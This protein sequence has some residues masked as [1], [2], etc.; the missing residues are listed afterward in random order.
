M[1]QTFHFV[2]PVECTPGTASSWQ[3]VDLDSYVSGLGSDVTGVILHVV[4]THASTSYAIG[5]RKNGSTDNRRNTMYCAGHGWVAIGVDSS[6]IFEL[7]VGETSSID[8]YIVGY[9]TTGVTLHT[10]AVDRT[11]TSTLSVWEDIDCSA[12][13]PNAIAL[14][15][16]MATSSPADYAI[17]KNGSSDD[18]SSTLCNHGAALIGCDTSQIFEG[19]RA[20]SYCRFWLVGY[21]TDGLS[22]NTNGVDRSLSATGSYT[23]KTLT[24]GAIGGVIEV[25]STASSQTYA[26]RKNGSSED[27]YQ[28][29]AYRHQFGIVE[30]DASGIIEGKISNTAVDFFEIGIATAP[31]A[32]GPSGISEVDTV[33]VANIAEAVT[34]AWSSIDEVNTVT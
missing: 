9:T 12:E 20:G 24:S 27:I 26:L 32:S 18:R 11:P 4:N 22:M 7:Y 31:A 6:H 19:K 13:A 25:K 33:A 15:F 21:A 30:A 5:F 23:D 2:D 28:G 1:A 3:D 8:V 29:A 10:N 34:V 16:E 17:R 14:I